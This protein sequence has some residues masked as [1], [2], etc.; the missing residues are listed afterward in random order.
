MKWFKW[1]RSKATPIHK[2]YASIADLPAPVRKLPKHGQEIYLA[3]FNA[4]FKEYDGDEGK[5]HATAWA[6]V[7]NKYEQV[8]GRWVAKTED[9]PW[10]KLASM[11]CDDSLPIPWRGVTHRPD[12]IS[13]YVPIAKADPDRRLVYGVVLEP[14]DPKHLDAQ[15]DFV[16]TE[17]IELS[18]HDFMKRYRRQRA[19]MGLQ[20]EE[21]AAVDIVESYIAPEDFTLGEGQV[22]KGSWVLVTY[23]RDEDMWQG[24]KAGE[25]TGFSIGGEGERIEV[26]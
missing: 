17:E 20:H 5:A 21:E 9:D 12:E 26:A 2:P 4:A 16:K 10:I 6:A 23:V 22:K 15:K 1:L 18:A 11:V 8:D 14:G 24:V 7:K 25:L 13:W 3:A 19:S